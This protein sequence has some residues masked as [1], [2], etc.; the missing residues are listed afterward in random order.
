MLMKKIVLNC[1]GANAHKVEKI[2]AQKNYFL[3]RE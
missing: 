3:S 2:G 1:S